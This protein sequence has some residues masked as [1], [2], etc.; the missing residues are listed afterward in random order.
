MKKIIKSNFIYLIIVITTAALSYGY[1]ITHFAIG[2][3]DTAME[4]YFEEG[5]SV[6]TNRWTVFFLNRV[7]HLNI[8]N[9]PTWLVECLAVCIL[10]L[11][12]SLWCYIIDRILISIEITLSGWFYGLSVALA[13]S[14]PIMSEIWVYYM[15]NGVAIAYGLTALALQFFLQSLQHN[16]RLKPV[17]IAGSGICLATAIG[18]YETMMDCFLIGALA[19]F[20][21]LHAFSYKKK[22]PIYDIRFLPWTIKGGIVLAIS[23]VVRALMHKILMSVYDLDYM[24]KYGVNNYNSVFGNLF[25][26]P[27][28]LGLLIKKMYLRY[29]VNAVAYL[30]ITF[31]VLAGGVIG[32][33][34][35]FWTIKKKTP[36]VIACVPTIA[37]VPVLSSIVAGRAKEYHSAQFV[38][39]VIMLGFIFLGIAL[40][41]DKASQKVPIYRGIIIIAAC[42][43]ITQIWDINRWFAQDY[44]KYL[45][46]KQIMTDAAEEL[47]ENFDI[48][49]PVVVVGATLPSDELCREAS[50][51]M[52]S[53]KYH[54]ITSLTSFDPTIKEKFHANYGGWCYFYTESPLL[55]VLTWARN[56]FENCDLV[57]SQQYTNFWK[58]I[59]YSDF[60]YVPSAE[61]IE[62]AEKIR[63]C[64]KMAGYPREGYIIDNGDMLIVNLSEVE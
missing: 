59:G 34:A 31:L 16:C 25:H 22:N 36:W 20:M 23:L 27:G 29:C 6:C 49:K 60:V 37:F 52:D 2:V 3:D 58:M 43:I 14:C 64:I 13:I 55:S 30:P 4:L 35:V 38:P 18:C 17:K 53:W 33:L 8:I 50:I 63:K 9:W 5:L 32:G 62:E 28:A 26:T 21:I 54:L 57:A 24:V 44:S 56:P 15:H 51:S 45:E 47:I 39:I 41:S 10:V 46:A 42:G 1:N 61:M 48:K 11:S 12:F 40:Y 7:L 19:V